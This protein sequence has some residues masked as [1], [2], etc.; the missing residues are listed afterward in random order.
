[1]G[2]TDF[3]TSTTH[4]I[5]SPGTRFAVDFLSNQFERKSTGA[6]AWVY[7]NHC[8]WGQMFGGRDFVPQFGILGKGLRATWGMASQH[9]LSSQSPLNLERV[10]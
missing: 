7:R 1:M 10:L 9:G 4:L 5:R 6:S 2:S 3:D 8:F